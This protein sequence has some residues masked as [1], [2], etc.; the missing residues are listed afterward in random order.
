M[1]P[2]TKDELDVLA[3]AL[4]VVVR[5]EA[6][7]LAQRGVASIKGD[8]VGVLGKRLRLCVSALAKVEE[9]KAAI[10]QAEAALAQ[11]QAEGG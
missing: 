9:Q 11:P 5:N 7:A 10:V 4:D 3:L 6:S 8:A 2:F 1:P